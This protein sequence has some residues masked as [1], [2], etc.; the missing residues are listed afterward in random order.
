MNLQ[1]L[2]VYSPFLALLYVLYALIQALRGKQQGVIAALL[3]FIA[4]G[5][6]L[7]AYVLTS[8]AIA[9]AQ[10]VEYM[11]INAAVVFIASILMLLIERRRP[12]RDLNRSYGMLGIG[13]SILLALGIFITP[14][15]SR[16]LPG[17]NLAGATANNRA[18][19]STL[20]TVSALTPGAAANGTAQA[21]TP[22]QVAQV[23][24]T[25]TGLSVA[26]LTTQL[27]GGSTTIAQLVS[28]NNGNLNAVTTAIA[29]AL[30]QMNASGGQSAQFISRLGTDTTAVATQI[31]QGQLQGRAAQFIIPILLTGTLPQFGG[32]NGGGGGFGGSGAA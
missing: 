14:L 13:L 26:D 11:V 3:A 20:Q 12:D 29:T 27:T 21:D 5:T 7:A 22:S 25:Q 31:V 10:L 28:A 4:M 8:D 16:A 32:G 15:I 17:G 6:S 30:D 24:S 2:L 19:H 1:T 18:G 9:K 23:L